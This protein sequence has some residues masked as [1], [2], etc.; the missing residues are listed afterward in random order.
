MP[1]VPG[2]LLSPNL[3]QGLGCPQEVSEGLSHTWVGEQSGEYRPFP[4]TR[5]M[6]T[7]LQKYLRVVSGTLMTTSALGAAE[8][9]GQRT[10]KHHGGPQGC[11]RV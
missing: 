9:L 5:E 7:V 11:S 1:S 10:R 6:V 3:Q 4:E 2:P 8:G